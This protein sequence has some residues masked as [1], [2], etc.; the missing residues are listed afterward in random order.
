MY[1]CAIT[2]Q[3]AMSSFTV[4]CGPTWAAARGSVRQRL[5]TGVCSNATPRA[6]TQSSDAPR[7]G[8]HLLLPASSGT[9]RKGGEAPG[10]AWWQLTPPPEGSARGEARPAASQFL[11][12]SRFLKTP[13]ASSQSAWGAQC[14]RP[15][16]HG[17]RQGC[18]CRNRHRPPA[19]PLPQPP[20]LPSAA[21]HRYCTGNGSRSV[22]VRVPGATTARPRGTSVGVCTRGDLRSTRPSSL[23]LHG[24][25]GCA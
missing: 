16:L 1:V 3:M 14:V 22:R 23:P 5:W 24:H 13:H 8:S 15:S 7:R 21:Q 4:V 10:A 18:S 19:V 25:R 6:V 9:A 2:V 20:V 12:S 17:Q 11:C